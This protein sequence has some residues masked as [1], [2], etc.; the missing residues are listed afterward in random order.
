MLEKAQHE[1]GPAFQNMPQASRVA[2]E[3]GREVP[4]T[5]SELA[6]LWASYLESSIKQQMMKYFLNTIEDPEIG[7]ILEYTMGIARKHLGWL[8]DLYTRENHPIPRGFTGE[9]VNP[10]APR[11]FSDSFIL[12]FLQHLTITRMEGYTTAMQMSTRTDVRQF[13]SECLA[14]PVE[15]YNRVVSVMQTRGI[16]IRAPQ[17]NIPGKVNFVK[18]KNY[19]TGFTGLLGRGRGLNSIEISHLF[20]GLQKNAYREAVFKG[21]GQVAALQKVRQYM[22]RGRQISRKHVEIFSS[23]LI[24]NGLPVSMPWESGVL[25]TKV[26]PFSDK[27]MMQHCRVSS[28][29]LFAAYGKAMPFVSTKRNLGLDFFRLM[30]EIFRY[31]KDGED[32]LIKN[33]WYE[34]PPQ[35]AGGREKDKLLH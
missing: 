2:L 16:L 25:G 18:N 23:L 8:D 3:G 22:A 10:D 35:F 28:V 11:L 14:D 5:A 32:I 30:A 9:D 33:G 12:F 29:V 1:G 34:K 6:N 19:F 20:H 13:F 26:A 24:K 15:I 31:V 7:E 4:L 21:F 27:L 17:I